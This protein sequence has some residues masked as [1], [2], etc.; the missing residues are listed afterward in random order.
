[1]L[2]REFLLACLR[3]PP[4]L[5]PYTLPQFP[6]SANSFELRTTTAQ[7]LDHRTRLSLS[8]SIMFVMRVLVMSLLATLS[9]AYRPGV[10]GILQR[11]G[12]KFKGGNSWQVAPL[13]CACPF[14]QC[15]ASPERRIC[16][17]CRRSLGTIDS[18]I[19]WVGE[20]SSPGRC[21]SCASFTPHV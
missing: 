1:M 5:P 14:T 16:G 21:L 20:L 2:L 11:P 7:L 12:R 8:K 6:M 15:T 10:D 9:L 18:R 13:P 17:L 4:Q 3:E 19:C